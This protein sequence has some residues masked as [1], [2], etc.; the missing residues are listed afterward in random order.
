MSAATFTPGEKEHKTPISEEGARVAFSTPSSC[1]CRIVVAFRALH[2]ALC[3]DCHVAERATRPL[4]A[5][6]PLAPAAT[7]ATK[8]ADSA[9]VSAVAL[10]ASLPAGRAPSV[11]S[12]AA[13][14]AATPSTTKLAATRGTATPPCAACLAAA[15][16]PPGNP[17]QLAGRSRSGDRQR[18]SLSNAPPAAVEPTAHSALALTPSIG[19][20]R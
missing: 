5:Q 18:N 13:S 12:C 14:P 6:F 15:S 16:R 8:H 4:V 3:T 9:L 10:P 7:S 19:F 11:S 20:D 17:T 2:I 1:N